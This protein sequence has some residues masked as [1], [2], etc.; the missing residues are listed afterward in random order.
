MKQAGPAVKWQHKIHRTERVKESTRLACDYSLRV[1][2]NK[3]QKRRK[4]SACGDGHKQ[5][6]SDLSFACCA[7]PC[8]QFFLVKLCLCSWDWILI[9]QDSESIFKKREI[10]KTS[11]HCLSTCR[12]LVSLTLYL[13]LFRYKPAVSNSYRKQ[14]FCFT[15]EILFQCSIF[16]SPR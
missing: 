9:C 13:T 15:K 4:M 1:N 16:H 5:Q 12:D 10:Y 8:A 14:L 2:R 11:V 6:N 3:N 7:I